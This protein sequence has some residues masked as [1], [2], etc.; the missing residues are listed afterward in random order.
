MINILLRKNQKN[1]VLKKNV[2]PNGLQKY[3]R[4][5]ISNKSSFIDRI[6]FLISLLDSLVKNFGKNDLKYLSQEL[7]NN[8]LHLVKQKGFYPYEYM[9]DFEKFEEQLPSK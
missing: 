9:R 8:A 3:M 6:R 5:R 2:R 4:V 1:S 7:D